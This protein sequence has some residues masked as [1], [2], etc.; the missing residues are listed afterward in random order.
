MKVCRATE[1]LATVTRVTPP[2]AR[3]LIVDGVDV[4]PCAV[5][6]TYLTRLRGLLG[7]RGVDGG[8]LLTS[9]SSVHGAGMTF[10]LDVAQLDADLVVIRTARL[11]PFGLVLPRRGV[12][13]VLEAESGA[14]ARWRLHRGSRVGVL[15]LAAAV[16]LALGGCSSAPST[17]VPGDQNPALAASASAGPDLRALSEAPRGYRVVE[18]KGFTIAAPSAFQQSQ[19][20]SSTGEPTVVLRR[21]SSVSALPSSVVVLRDPRAKQDV[22][23]QSYALDL[24]KRTAAKATDVERLDVVWPGARRAVLVRWTENVPVGGGITVPARY[25]QLNAQITDTLVIVVVALAPV[26][27]LDT[28]AVATVLRTFAPAS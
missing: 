10:S 13:H 17:T 11:H 3:R 2:A 20:T 28:S 7:R 4:G 1:R 9:C 16:V 22:V 12:R 15:S 24:A 27:D 14:F 6:D 5:A 18:G 23:E 25:L 8:L 19:T 21:P 26:A